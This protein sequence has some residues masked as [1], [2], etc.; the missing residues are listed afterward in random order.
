MS[1]HSATPEM[2]TH[3]K[4]IPLQEQDHSSEAAGGAQSGCRQEMKPIT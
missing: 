1:G 2:M 3:L 4:A